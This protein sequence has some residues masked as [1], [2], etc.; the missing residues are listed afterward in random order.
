MTTGLL[1]VTSCVLGAV[2]VG[3]LDRGRVVPLEDDGFVAGFVPDEP[4]PTFGFGPE[5]TSG[6]DPGCVVPGDAAP[7]GLPPTETVPGRFELGSVDAVA[8]K[9]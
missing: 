1:G 9:A 5:V 2:V 8:A 6:L 7:V 3:E 4:E